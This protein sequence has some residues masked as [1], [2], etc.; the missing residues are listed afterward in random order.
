MLLRFVMYDMNDDNRWM[1]VGYKKPRPV[2]VFSS[3]TRKAGVIGIVD[4]I[5]DSMRCSC[6]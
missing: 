3:S 1:C 6:A 2:S 5:I 4:C